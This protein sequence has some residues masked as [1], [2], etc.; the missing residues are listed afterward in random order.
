MKPKR[1]AIT[2]SGAVSLGSYEAGVLYEIFTAIEQHN[3][4]VLVDEERIVVDVLTG[5]SAGGMTA[6]IGAQMLA[7]RKPSSWKVHDNPFYNPWVKEIDLAGLARMRDG[8]DPMKSLLSSDCIEEIAN[9]FLPHDIDCR[10]R[11]PIAPED[12]AIWLG[13]ALSNLTGVDHDVDALNGTNF[14][15]TRHQDRLVRDVTSAKEVDWREIRRAGLACGA[16]P[17]AF[18]VRDLVRRWS[19]YF[20]GCGPDCYR[21]TFTYTD[22]G[23]FDNQPLGMA[24][25]LVARLDEPGDND[26]RYYLFVSPWAKGSSIAENPLRAKDAGFAATTK[27]LVGAVFTQ[28]RFQDWVMAES[29]NKDLSLLN[30]RAEQLATLI[31]ED[32]EVA[33]AIAPAAGRLAKEFIEN[34]SLETTHTLTLADERQRLAKECE[35]LGEDERDYAEEIRRQ[36]G[37]EAV[38][39]WLDAVLVLEYAAKLRD[40]AEM[41]IYDITADDDEIG[42]E[43]LWAFGG[44]LDERIRHHDYEV[45]RRKAQEWI[46]N[47]PT[48]VEKTGIRHLGPIN[49]T[50][51]H[52]P[53][54]DEDNLATITLE[55]T[56]VGPR[57]LLKKIV[58]QRVSAL[59]K[60]NFTAWVIGPPVRWVVNKKIDSFIADKLKL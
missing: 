1:L 20:D 8:E 25:N 47:L 41:V 17:L 34:P 5:A 9:K 4:K 39:G 2:I 31:L 23:V 43:E 3:T 27:A 19:E 33:D 36:R 59:I 35:R 15:Y 48:G 55:K 50:P 7:G 53:H 13:L 51:D 38:N 37:E 26:S 57:R 28:A 49:Y 44:F 14:I 56:P 11:H 29:V 60:E 10:H 42:G 21:P 18:R 32:R 6:A 24:R 16:F 30:T 45:G 46:R 54:P 12:G 52:V 22:G 58:M 40:K